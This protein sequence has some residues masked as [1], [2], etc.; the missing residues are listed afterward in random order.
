MTAGEVNR[1]ENVTSDKRFF[2]DHLDV[3]RSGLSLAE[4]L[5][6]RS[7]FDDWRRIALIL[8]HNGNEKC[9]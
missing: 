7:V 5:S 8:F 2:W 6:L 3:A 9:G 4:G 1:V